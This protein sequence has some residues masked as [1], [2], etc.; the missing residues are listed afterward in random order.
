[1]GNHFLI[2]RKNGDVIHIYH[3]KG[4]GIC[5][6]R[7]KVEEHPE[8]L[9]RDGFYDFDCWYDKPNDRIHI[10]CQNS[11]GSIC[12]VLGEAEGW[13]KREILTGRLK[14][15]YP[16]HFSIWSDGVK[17]M[18]IYSI[19]HNG[20]VLLVS[21]KE[22]EDV[23]TVIDYMCEESNDFVV[24]TEGN[25]PYV[26]YLDREK[27]MKMQSLCGQRWKSQQL[28]FDATG[29]RPV[30]L[31]S[32]GD[33]LHFITFKKKENETHILYRKKRDD[34]ESP[35][36][37]VRIS[38]PLSEVTFFEENG[39]PVMVLLHRE[40]TVY[41]RAKTAWE[42]DP[43]KER[44]IHHMKHP[45]R[46]ILLSENRSETV[47]FFEGNRVHLLH[48]TEF[49]SQSERNVKTEDLEKEDIETALKKLKDRVQRMERKI[50]S[51]EAT[52][53]R[54]FR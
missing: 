12:H 18:A 54:D 20:D 44:L 24:G 28:P 1:M 9:L 32:A 35:E 52:Y 39:T 21:Q 2:R 3:M 46:I 23:P 25:W 10:I 50:A 41:R 45:T 34:W 5:T 37:V 42:E 26:F 31:H 40:A 47:G 22:D 53:R 4:N 16:K 11:E 7:L 33:I 19:R 48:H 14:L 30:F 36:E 29:E 49:L 51:I 13:K 17:E 43:V 38:E 8:I 15:P 6:H 27:T